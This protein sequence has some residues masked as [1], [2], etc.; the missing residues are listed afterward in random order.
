MVGGRND[1]VSTDNA[2]RLAGPCRKDCEVRKLGILTQCHDVGLLPMTRGLTCWV[3]GTTRQFKG[4][5]ALLKASHLHLH[6]AIS[7]A[8][9][10]GSH[11]CLIIRVFPLASSLPIKHTLYHAPPTQAPVMNCIPLSIICFQ[12][13]TDQNPCHCKVVGPTIGFGVA[14][15]LAIIY[16]P[17]S[18]F[19][20]CGSK[21]Q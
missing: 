15:V 3:S 10:S 13:G 21:F 17:T 1:V 14:V 7:I 19:F 16:Y 18:I 2:R 12:C 6:L 4:T 9:N 8:I 11:C 20:G 5:W